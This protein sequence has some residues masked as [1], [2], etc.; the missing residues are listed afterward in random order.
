MVLQ[1]GLGLGASPRLIG[2]RHPLWLVFRD[3][4]PGRVSP[5]AWIEELQLEKRARYG[6]IQWLIARQ[7]AVIAL[8]T[9]QETVRAIAQQ[10]GVFRPPLYNWKNELF[11][12]E[13]SASMKHN[14][15]LPRRLSGS[16]LE[17]R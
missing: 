3:G 1:K 13:V 11:G 14:L 12:R 17:T 10:L 15:N 16:R 5:Y 7:A 2:Q 9:R 8:C 4:Y 6:Q